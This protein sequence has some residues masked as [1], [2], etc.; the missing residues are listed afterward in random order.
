M[1][2]TTMIVLALW[3]GPSLVNIA[4][5]LVTAEPV[6]DL[7]EKWGVIPPDDSEVRRRADSQAAQRAIDTSAFMLSVVLVGL[8]RRG[9]VSDDDAA[10]FDIGEFHG[11]CPLDQAR[12]R[13]GDFVERLGLDEELEEDIEFV[14]DSMLRSGEIAC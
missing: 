12:L 7:L 14:L 6:V 9:V 11:D 8:V 10:A 4:G 5:E 1:V 13:F 2:F 3:D